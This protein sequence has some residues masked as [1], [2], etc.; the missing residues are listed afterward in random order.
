MKA[1]YKS[2]TRDQN[3]ENSNQYW[4]TQKQHK[5]WDYTDM[6]NTCTHTDMQNH[7]YLMEHNMH[8]LQDII[9]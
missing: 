3:T 7:T 5:Y 6:Q 8:V 2:K 9:T 1:T 4:W